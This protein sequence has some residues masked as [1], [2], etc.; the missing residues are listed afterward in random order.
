MSNNHPLDLAAITP[1]LLSVSLRDTEVL[2]ALRRVA[3]HYMQRLKDLAKQ[4]NMS[5][6]AM[7]LENSMNRALSAFS[8]K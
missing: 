4:H 2:T 3:F 1:Y 6:L 5:D 8:R 7:Q